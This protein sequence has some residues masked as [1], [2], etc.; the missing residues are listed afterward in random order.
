MVET[1][2]EL[3]MMLPSGS[4]LMGSKLS[5]SVGTLSEIDKRELARTGVS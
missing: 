4:D 2:D 1:G 3:E 5:A